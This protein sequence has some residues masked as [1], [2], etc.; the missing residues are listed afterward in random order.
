MV[1]LPVTFITGTRFPPTASPEEHPE[2]DHRTH[3]MAIHDHCASP[4]RMNIIP[5]RETRRTKCG[6]G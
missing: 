6:G 2:T 1:T 4:L 5:A 3:V